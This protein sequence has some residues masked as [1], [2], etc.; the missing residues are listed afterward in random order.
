MV[1]IV[2]VG[3]TAAVALRSYT[4]DRPARVAT[5]PA[6]STTS[7]RG[8][9]PVTAQCPDSYR[10]GYVPDGWTA[11][12]PTELVGPNGNAKIAAVASSTATTVV[13]R[14]ELV[15]FPAV[16]RTTS[17]GN[18]HEVRID[19]SDGVSRTDPKCGGELAVVVYGLSQDDAGRV[20]AG[21]Q[22]V[23][24]LAERQQFRA[25]WPSS[26]LATIV[27][28][29]SNSGFSDP[30]NV[31]LLFA[32]QHGWSDP[33][34]TN[35][36][37]AEDG[38]GSADLVI[39]GTGQPPLYLVLT[40]VPT[41]GYWAVSY[42]STFSSAPD[43]SLSVS[44]TSDPSVPDTANS[45]FGDAATAELTIKYGDQGVDLTATRMPPA[46]TF[47]VGAHADIPGALTIM[48]RDSNGK[49]VAIHSAALPPGDF[50]AG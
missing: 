44:I 4:S 41:T 20:V 7:R 34:V 6:T 36:Q 11:T 49:V 46:W 19:D 43:F 47:E 16:D 48:W 40:P 10:F 37:P 30:S 23:V 29:A 39:D 50:A 42:A 28:T 33:A 21:V 24:T 35:K 13:G 27:D 17:G 5:S 45:N 26:D 38:T 1:A 9:A 3:V 31:A 12:S 8:T 14:I 18:V 22:P 15:G 25:V 32:Q 2:I